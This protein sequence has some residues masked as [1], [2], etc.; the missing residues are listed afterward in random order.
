PPPVTLTRW[1]A[2]GDTT[3]TG[4]TGAARISGHGVATTRTATARTGS[5]E[6][7]QA[8]PASTSDSGRNQAAYR[9]ARRTN[10]ALSA[11]ACSTSR[12]MPEYVD[13]AAVVV[14]RRSN[15]PP[16][17]TT[18]EGT[19]SPAGRVTGA[20]SPVSADS[21]RTA[22]SRSTRPST[23]TTSPLRTS[24]RSPGRTAATG[25]TSSSPSRYRRA[26]TG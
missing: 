1:R 2:A 3:D 8:S 7:S 5:P 26:S 12:A 20:A 16:A 19:P 15:A 6:T 24:S 4:A 23:G 17:L 25:T 9:S 18:P 13:S 14:A 22:A 21:S 11:E 10:G